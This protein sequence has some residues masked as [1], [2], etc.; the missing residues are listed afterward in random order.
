MTIN[1]SRSFIDGLPHEMQIAQR[2]LETLEVQEMLQKLA[3]YNLGICMPHMHDETTGQFQVMPS[4]LTQVEDGLRVSFRPTEEVENND[5]RY[6]PVGWFWHSDGTLG[7]M[8][9]TA[10]CVMMG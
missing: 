10:R 8:A 5:E 3:K 6:V 9:C 2:A 4:G 7:R 1:A